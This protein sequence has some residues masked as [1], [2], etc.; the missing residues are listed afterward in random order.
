[1]LPERNKPAPNAQEENFRNGLLGVNIPELG[2]PIRGKV[3]DCW[4]VARED[5]TLRVIVTTDRQSAFDR[6]ICTVSGKGA[7]LNKI[8]QHWFERTR[9][10][11]PNHI[12]SVPHPNVTIA[13]E[14]LATLPVEIVLRRYM[15][16]SSTST[17]VYR[18]YVEGGKREI[19]GIEFSEGLVANQEF[20]MGTIVTPTTKA[21][22]GQHDE[23]LTDNQAR[24]I[25]DQKFGPGIWD[26]AKKLSL[27]VFERG[28][29]ESLRNGLIL[30]DTKFE[31]GLDDN[32][33]LMLI[34]ELLT[35][36]SSRY[37][38]EAS[39]EDKF[40]RGENPV[41]FDKEILRR[42]LAEQGFKGDGI[43]PMIDPDIIRRMKEA[44]L[45]PY[46]MMTGEMDPLA[47]RGEIHTSD[48]AE[49]RTAVL[50]EL[51]RLKHT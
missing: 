15:A 22:H 7:V 33:N 18:N 4:V 13:K 25:V 45:S 10:I 28:R 26:E 36:D 12:V 23:P 39:Y 6:Q 48:A 30:V 44:Y 8:S 38:L 9:D 46:T 49:I 42:W 11:V 47:E 37:W 1:M 40:E 21:E 32:G 2:S 29:E 3:R 20:P 19:Y 24:Q 51:D 31:I 14:A 34:D 5:D 43:V 27:A 50:S 35:P 17:S 41:S 16:K